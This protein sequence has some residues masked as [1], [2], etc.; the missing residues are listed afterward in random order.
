MSGLSNYAAGELL[1]H[2]VTSSSPLFL[3]LC[4]EIPT[5]EDTGTT[6]IE[7]TYTGYERV[8]VAAGDWSAPSGRRM[9][10]AVDIALAP[11]TAGADRIV[12][13]ALCDADTA[14]EVIWEGVVP[15]FIIDT[16]DP[17]PLLPASRLVLVLG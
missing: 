3:A 13:W 16:D 17:A 12:G 9:E 10:N 6:L 14:G 2:S 11:C 8:A 1:V 4:T 7:A 5:R 15:A